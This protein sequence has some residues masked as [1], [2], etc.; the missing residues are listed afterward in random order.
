M[1]S[2]DDNT[3]CPLCGHTGRMAITTRQPLAWPPHQLNPTSLTLFQCRQCGTVF[4][5]LEQ[6]QAEEPVGA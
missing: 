5:N 3:T 6:R 4:T 1:K 2:T